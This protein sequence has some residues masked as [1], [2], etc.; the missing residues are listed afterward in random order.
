MPTELED[1]LFDLRGYLILENAVD[2]DHL[3]ALNATID[4]LLPIKGD[5]WKGHVYAR[6]DNAYFNVTEAGDSFERLIDHPSWIDHARRYIGEEESGLFI[7]ESFVDIRGPGM[8]TRMHGGGHKRKTRAQFRYHDGFFRCG[9]VNIL[10][11]LVDIGPGDGAATATASIPPTRC[12]PGSPPSAA[13]SS[14]RSLP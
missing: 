4:A 1:Y 12:W 9:Q 3:Q 2:A 8:A 7:D 14:S 13:R 5:T 11:A 10:L 6:H